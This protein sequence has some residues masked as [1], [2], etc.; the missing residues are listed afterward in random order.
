MV[1]AQCRTRSSRRIRLLRRL[2]SDQ[3]IASRRQISSGRARSQR[4]G[5]RCFFGASSQS[6]R[7]VGAATESLKGCQLGFFGVLHT[8][9][10][11]P[12]TYHPHV[13]YVVPGGGVK[14]DERGHALSWQR[15]PE[16]FCSIT[17]H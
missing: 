17:E 6:V 16:N 11:D 10:R 1:I 15:T 14:L 3:A 12:A 5:Y 13:H 2:E 4:D 8:W 7:D 9:G